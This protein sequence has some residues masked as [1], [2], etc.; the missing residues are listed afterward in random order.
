M[1]TRNAIRFLLFRLLGAA[2]LLGSSA[3]AADL[4]MQS[5]ASDG[6]TI[7]VKPLDVSAKAATWTFQVSLNTH[8]QDLS[9]DLLRTA[10]IV[11]RADKKQLAP[12]TWKGDAQGGHHRSGVLSFKA[13]TPLPKAIELRVQRVGEKAPRLFRW[14]LDCPCN[15]P[16]M[17]PS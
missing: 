9:D 2:L 16:K 11:D 8:S 14:D 7:E 1:N 3:F 15:D 12:S 17:H 10:Y 6:V 13:P 5:S 4:A